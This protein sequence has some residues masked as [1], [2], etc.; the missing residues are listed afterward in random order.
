[1]YLHRRGDKRT[2]LSVASDP[3]LSAS[4]LDHYITDWTSAGDTTE[5]YWNTW[6]R[7]HRTYW[8]HHGHPSLPVLPLTPVKVH[9]LGMLFKIATYRAAKNYLSAAKKMHLD[10]GYRWSEFLE[11]A[12]RR[13]NLSTRRGMGPPR[14]SAPINFEFAVT[15][16]FSDEA[17]IEGGPIGMQSLIVM[18]TLWLVRG[19][20]GMMAN[21]SH[22]RMSWEDLTVTWKLAV[23]KGDAAALGCERTWGCTCITMDVV[24]RACPFHA[25]AKQLRLLESKFGPQRHDDDLPLFPTASGER[26][27]TEVMAQVVDKVAVMTGEAVKDENGDNRFGNHSWRSAGAVYLT[28]IG[29]EVY[30]VQ[31]L[32]RWA[33]AQ[34]L[35]YTRLAPLKGLTSKFKEAL[36]NK[37]RA[38]KKARGQ[39]PQLPDHKLTSIVDEKVATAVSKIVRI[40]AATH[41]KEINELK[42]LIATATGDDNR[43]VLNRRAKVKHRILTTFNDVGCQA[44]ARCGFAYAAP[45]AEISIIR[46]PPIKAKECCPT[47]FPALRASLQ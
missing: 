28:A 24:S 11:L 21:R 8:F 29:I 43:I 39:N 4:A 17:I 19:A 31:M 9:I 18:F 47:C 12:S 10:S 34:V 5:C 26:V 41:E 2:A 35:H 40:H 42:R 14:Q 44:R 22:I 46:D 25:A 16:H 6:C 1:M 7:F 45:T 37:D 33:C 20:E 23:S 3:N 15:L 13:F 38:D 32:A 36:M 27:E 30:I